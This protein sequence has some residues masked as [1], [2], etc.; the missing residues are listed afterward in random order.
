[1]PRE[2]LYKRCLAEND[3]CVLCGELLPH[4][5]AVCVADGGSGGGGVSAGHSGGETMNADIEICKDS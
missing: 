4:N 5:G 3:R 1:M 2:R